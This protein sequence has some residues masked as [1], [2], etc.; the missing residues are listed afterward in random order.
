MKVP[1]AWL[2]EYVPLTLPPAELAHRLTMAGIEATYEP[3]ASAGWDNVI[4]GYVLK[5]EPHPNAD[6][7]RLATVDLGGEVATV[8]CGAPNVSEGQRIAFAQVG[9]RLFSAHGG[10]EG[11]RME[12]EA[13]TIRGVVSAGMVCSERELGLS[14]DHTGILVLPDDAPVGEPLAKYI[15]DDVL[16]L[17]VTTNRVDCLSVLGVAREVAAITGATVTEPTLDYDEAGPDINRSV[18]VRIENPGLCSRYLA[19]VVRG[20]QVGPSPQWMQQRLTQAGLRPIN[21]V[22]DVT[23]FV[24]MEYG[25]PLHAFDLHTVRQGTIVVRPATPG[26][27]FTTLDG[28]THTLH[29]PMLLIADPEQGIALAGVMGGAQSEMTDSTTDVL[30]E[31]ATFDGLNTRRTSQVLKMRTEASARFEKGL[32]AELA[33]RALRRATDLILRTAGGQADTGIA[34]AFP[35]P[36]RQEPIRLRNNRLEQV[37]GVRFSSDQVINVLESLGFGVFQEP[38]SLLATPPYWRSD[39]HIEEDLI[40]EVARIIGYDAIPSTPLAG[41]MPDH[42]TQPLRELREQVKDLLVSAG[43]QEVVSYSLVSHALLEQSAAIDSGQPEPLRVANPMSREQ[44][45]LRTTLRGGLLRTMAG[46]LRQPPGSLRLFE[47]G[48]VYLHRLKELPEERELA[49]GA[50]AGPRGESLWSKAAASLDF[51][52]AKGVL[53]GLLQRL[54]LNP[55]FEHASDPLLHPGRTATASVNGHVV[56]LIGELHPQAVESF[57]LPVPLVA[58]FELDLERLL[59]EL[60]EVEPQYQPFSRF[61]AAD[62]D[63]ALVVDEPVTADQLRRILEGHPLVRRAVL[64]DLFSGSP[65]PVGK[66]SLAYRVELQSDSGTLSAEQLNEAMAEL[67]QR[68]KREAGASL[69][70]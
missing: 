29:P 39:V 8:V 47:V 46:G 25:Q 22:V 28:A 7:L 37:L 38:D 11:Q 32:N 57:D 58:C 27:P 31:S 51:Y 63:L 18:A 68:L 60:P 53:E 64:F 49:F 21:N 61:P 6:R 4:V 20:V 34:E 40:E 43:M 1:L 42:L 69:R 26:E 36:P 35:N 41:Q 2:A 12:L 19:T 50:M 67:V 9:A 30:V 66:K 55:T 59:A 17:E 48:R 24:M 14:D 44:E 54:G 5:V 16:N 23:N 56:G 10:D 45:Y 62:R 65:L 52:D 3:G 70:S 33:M 13:A 15:S